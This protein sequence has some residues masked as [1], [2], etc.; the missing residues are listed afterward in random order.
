MYNLNKNL[1]PHITQSSDIQRIVQD[2][3]WVSWDECRDPLTLKEVD[4]ILA[5]ESGDKCEKKKKVKTLDSFL[6]KQ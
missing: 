1:Y 2:I 6:K 5:M 3:P 4:R